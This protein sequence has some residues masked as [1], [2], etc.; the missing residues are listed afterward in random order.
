M[1]YLPPS[2]T[3]DTS[4][5]LWLAASLAVSSLV[6]AVVF[7]FGFAYSQSEYQP[8]SLNS[9]SIFAISLPKT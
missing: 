9:H 7:A 2:Q 5:P 3:P 4:I 8:P 1:S 6:V